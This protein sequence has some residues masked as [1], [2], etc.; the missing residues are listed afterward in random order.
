[1]AI[2]LYNF[3][4]LYSLELTMALL[5]W[6]YLMAFRFQICLVM[7]SLLISALLGNKSLFSITHI[8]FPLEFLQDSAADFSALSLV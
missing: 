7:Y 3:P 2:F 8:I 6:Q 1:M 4:E 5:S